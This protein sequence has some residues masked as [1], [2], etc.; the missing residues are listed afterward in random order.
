MA[1][2]TL[3]IGNNSTNI[4]KDISIDV[5]VHDLQ[6]NIESNNLYDNFEN[7]KID[8]IEYKSY[9]KNKD[10]KIAYFESMQL[11][12]RNNLDILDFSWYLP[13]NNPNLLDDNSHYIIENNPNF[14]SNYENILISDKYTVDQNANILPLWYKHKSS[15]ITKV[16]EIEEFRSYYETKEYY[17]GYLIENGVLY[18]NYK[19]IYDYEND[20]YR[21]YI[22]TGTDNNGAI[23][24]ELLN[25]IPVFNEASWEDIY[26][27]EED[28]NDLKNGSFKNDVYTVQEVKNRWNFNI[29]FV[30]GF[31]ARTCNNGLNGF[32]WK[33]EVDKFIKLKQPSAIYSYDPWNI[34][35]QSS[36]VYQGLNGINYKYSI[37]EYLKQPYNPIFP[38]IKQNEKNCTKV[39]A[40]V[41]KVP[42]NKIKYDPNQN[43]N[44]DIIL[45]DYNENPIQIFTTDSTKANTVYTVD[46]NNV[47]IEY[48]YGD[49][50]SIDEDNGFIETNIQSLINADIVK[51][52][53]YEAAD[54]FVYLNVDL[55]PVNNKLLNDHKIVFYL[56]PQEVPIIQDSNWRA[57]EHL[58]VNYKDIIVSHSNYNDLGG[59]GIIDGT[60]SYQDF[61]SN[62]FIGYINDKQYLLLGEVF[63][64]DNSKLEDCFSFNFKDDNG[65][66][67]EVNEE[68]YRKNYKL[69]L[70]KFGFGNNG[71]PIQLNNLLYLT[72]PESVFNLAE[73][74]F[75]QRFY[76]YLETTISNVKEVDSPDLD[77]CVY[78]SF[79]NTK[80]IRYNFEGTGTYELYI[81]DTLE[82]T[83]IFSEVVRDEYV[84][85]ASSQ[86]T[87]S[88]KEIKLVYTP[89]S[90]SHYY[91]NVYTATIQW[92]L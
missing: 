71:M 61:L 64:K 46:S 63:Y 56:K 34:R 42:S 87:S 9:I 35:I 43:I 6:S 58:V 57:I 37:P 30:D 83:K 65:K 86:I 85:V 15:K 3:Y 27:N 62:N 72:V 32:F 89:D 1:N 21:F 38:C 59:L 29:F 75:K 13:N 20:S 79:L 39:T 11:N 66:Y 81:D 74:D 51:C 36:S 4:E 23:Y 76:T 44:L 90:K 69:Q 33:P 7:I 14:S 68:N 26:Y 40:N 80:V 77:L 47:A 84:D 82:D 92:R 5:I 88:T 78:Y 22:V 55:N 52:T 8:N 48:Q 12:S 16:T 28:I 53:Y 19:N 24:K 31:T 2:L 67:F 41:I 60:T 25:R 17:S 10:V 91:P 73:N 18:T 70:S 45:F 50:K 49:I 54:E